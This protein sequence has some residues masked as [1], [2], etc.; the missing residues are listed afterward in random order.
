MKQSLK[1]I[2][3]L[4][5]LIRIHTF[6]Q[7]VV[8]SMADMNY[9]YFGVDNK[10]DVAVSECNC[11]ELVVSSD[12]GS[13][14]GQGCHYY[15]KPN[16]I[17]VANISVKVKR[18]NTIDSVGTYQIMIYRVPDPVLTSSAFYFTDT[19][20]SK[21]ALIAQPTLT[22]KLP[23]FRLQYAFRVIQ[24]RLTIY[25]NDLIYYQ[26]KLYANSFS[27]AMK[28]KFSTLVNNDFLVFDEII[29]ESAEGTRNI[30]PV[31]KIY[32]HRNKD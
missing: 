14:T 4:F 6:A 26:E 20:R 17:G 8:V 24:Y 28:L 21:D 3:I 5:L 25:R 10:V 7:S 11:K 1:P 30:D 19:I 22:C 13:I 27:E 15:L 31:K 32:Y 16:R 18:K 29:L 23:G 9:G 12:N 2:F